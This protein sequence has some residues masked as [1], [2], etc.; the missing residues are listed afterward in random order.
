MDCELC[1]RRAEGKARI[2]GTVVSVCG[3]CARFGEAIYEAKPVKIPDKPRYR[4]PEEVYFV[5]NLA[6]VVK[7]AREDMNLA[8]EELA[9]RI[10][11]KSSVIERIE[12]GMR[13]EKH[14]VEKLERVIG[15]RLIS[16]AEAEKTIIEKKSSEPLTLGDVVTIKKK[17]KYSEANK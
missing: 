10:K 4:Q 11:E 15:V 13:P 9:E 12:K 7:N 2:E 17:K 8:R 6:A 3:A 5:D 16:S 1:G 14:V